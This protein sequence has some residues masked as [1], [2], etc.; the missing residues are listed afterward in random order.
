MTDQT[1]PQ[2]PFQPG[3]Q[4]GSQPTGPTWVVRLPGQPEF[5]ATTEQLQGL[6][7][8]GQL[9]GSTPVTDF[10]T[11][12][13]YEAKTIPGVFSDKDFL[14]ALLLSVLVGGLGIDRF[15]LGHIGLGILKLFTLGGCGVWAIID[16][17][18]IAI[19]NIRDAQGRPLAR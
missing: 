19:G 9:K 6:A 4:P 1:P 5:S 17:V 2:Q 18:L 14:I 16:I 8:Q 10:A 12:H 7:Q 11:G 13:S 3:Y 15:Y